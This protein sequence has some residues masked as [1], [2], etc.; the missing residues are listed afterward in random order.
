[1]DRLSKPAPFTSLPRS[2]DPSEIIRLWPGT[3]PG[4]QGVSLTY[5]S[6]DMSKDPGRHE[7]LLRHVAVPH[8]WVCRPERPD[9]SAALVIPGGGYT[10]I[11][12]DHEGFETARR[13]NK[14]GITAF[15]L[16]YRLPAEGWADSANVPLQDMQ[17]AMRLIRANAKDYAIDPARLGVVG[18]SA[19]GH[20]AATLA[21]RYAEQ[22][23]TPIDAADRIDP[24]PAFAGLV[25]PVITL[26]PGTHADSRNCLLGADQ[27]PARIAAYSCDQRV[28]P[29]TVPSYVTF[30]Q[31]DTLVP[32]GPNGLA[33]YKALM[34]ANVPVEL[35]AFENGPHGYGLTGENPIGAQNADLFLAWGKQG[36]WFKGV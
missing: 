9:G 33:M 24:K 32:P 8:L 25:Y 29:A 11:V 27:S 22:V 30:G 6:D 13:L 16:Q 7:R 2:A 3:P 18:F 34:A 31:N 28:T 17:R 10:V 1:M 15:V 20:M 23:Y 5:Q 12:V 26:G 36:G 35:H 14:A 4:G 21:T 19:G